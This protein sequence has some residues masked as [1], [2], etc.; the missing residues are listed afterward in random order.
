MAQR[1]LVKTEPGSYSYSDLERDKKT[2][3]TGVRNPVAAKH[4]RAMRSG[5]VVLVYHTGKEKAVVGVARVSKPAYPEPGADDPR[6]VAVDLEPL[7]ALPAPVALSALR[8]EPACKDFA[9][10]RVPRLSV[11]PVPDEAWDVVERR[12]KA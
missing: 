5:D 3:W 12:A 4:L 7:R 10:V 6:W 11:M 2:S 9:L 1:W 8:A